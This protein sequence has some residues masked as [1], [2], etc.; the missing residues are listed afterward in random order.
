VLAIFPGALGDLIC[1]AP[2]LDAIAR[3]NRGS[4]ME[5]MARAELAR[6]AVGRIARIERAHSIDRREIAT[7]FGAG[8]SEAREFFAQFARIES[9][10]A[11]DDVGFRAALAE[12]ARPAPVRFHPFRPPGAG[13]VADAYLRSVGAVAAADAVPFRVLDCDLSA[14]GAALERIGARPGRCVL[15]FPGSGSARKNWPL[16]NFVR[17]AT[18]IGGRTRVIAVLG[19]AERELASTL[20]AA[21]VAILRDL[22]LPVVA[23]LARIAGA[24]VGNDSG[25]SHLAAAAGARG[26]V[27]F[28]PTDPS[29]WRP[30]GAI[31]V[32]H[33]EPLDALGVESVLMALQ[34][35]AR[36]A[37][38]R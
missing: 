22:D 21:P 36:D 24:F 5:L 9:F 8:G 16:E 37:L 19:P 18:L 4:S 38:A 11:A 31:A 6:L 2:A 28:G 17:L 27:L 10:F 26:V 30:L 15:I 20:R 34:S 32:L 3:S 12:A 23:G 25:V 29:R 14:A 1:A 13:H 33:H 7:L 35:V